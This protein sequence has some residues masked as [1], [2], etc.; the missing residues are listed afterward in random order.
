MAKK[1][2]KSTASNSKVQFSNGSK[3][4]KTSIGKSRNSRKINKKAVR[5]RKGY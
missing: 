2:S 5:E 4:K 1:D 3:S